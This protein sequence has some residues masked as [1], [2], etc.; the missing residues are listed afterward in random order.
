[1]GEEPQFYPT[2]TFSRAQCRHRTPP[3]PIAPS[4]HR[5]IAPSYTTYCAVHSCAYIPVRV[6]IAAW[7]KESRVLQCSCTVHGR[8]QIEQPSNQLRLFHFHIILTDL[9]HI[10]PVF[11]F[12]TLLIA[13]DHSPSAIH[14]SEPY[15]HG[16][17]G[18]R[19]TVEALV[20][21]DWKWAGPFLVLKST[22]QTRIVSTNIE[23]LRIK[24]AAN[25]E[26][27]AV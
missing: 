11:N 1:M 12:N 7:T 10:A 27:C 13:I 21:L 26:Y 17:N 18:V 5:S 15:Q 22:A 2:W 4:L 23:W 16:T 3:S 14:A 19:L 24:K 20:E 6:H 9:A 8:F 25:R